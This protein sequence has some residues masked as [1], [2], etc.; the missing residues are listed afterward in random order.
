LFLLWNLIDAETVGIVFAFWYVSDSSIVTKIINKHRA[1]VKVRILVDPKANPTQSANATFLN[2][3]QAAGVPMRFKSTPY[4]SGGILHMK[5]MLFAG[6]NKLQFGTGNYSPA[7]FVTSQ[8]FVNYTL[9]ALY[10]TDDASV[11]NS[12]KTRFDDLWTDTTDYSKR[13]YRQTSA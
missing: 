6:Q 11:V 4:D 12:F 9:N 2:Q 7:S 8:P 3:F 1:G 5:M 10:F 13:D